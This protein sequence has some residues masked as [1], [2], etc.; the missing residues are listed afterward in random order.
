MERTPHTEDIW[1]K[2]TGSIFTAGNL[3]AANYQ[4]AKKSSRTLL[5]VHAF[6]VGAGYL[7]PLSIKE[8]DNVV[9]LG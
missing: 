8:N 6:I 2:N 3:F 1:Q 5:L 7:L 9:L 4:R